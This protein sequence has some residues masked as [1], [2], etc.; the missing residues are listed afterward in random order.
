[1]KA[2]YSLLLLVL[3]FNFAKA[4]NLELPFYDDFEESIGAPGI[5]NNWTIESLEGWQY[6]HIIPGQFVRF[7]NNDLDQ[8]DWLITKKINSTGAENLKVNFSYLYSTNKV[9]P[10]FY[11]TNQYN[12][13]AS[14]STWTELSFSF[15]ANE[16][17]WYSSDDYIIENPG[18]A[19]YFAFQYQVKANAGANFLLDNFSAKSYTPP[20]PF[21]LVGNSEHFEFYTNYADSAEYYFGMKDQL[22]KQFNK[23]ASIWEKPESNIKIYEKKIKVYYSGLSDIDLFDKNTPEWKSGFY[24]SDKFSIYIS[25]VNSPGKSAMYSNIKVLAESELSQLFLTIYTNLHYSYDSECNFIES[26]GLYES[27][28]KP[29]R[30]NVNIALDG[31]GH[32][33]SLADVKGLDKFT[34]KAKRELCVSYV[35]ACILGGAT[36]HIN[37]YYFEELWKYHLYYYYQIDESIALRLSK[38]TDHFNIF[39]I[40]RDDKY[41]NSIVQQ[42]EELLVYYSTSYAL[43]IKHPFNVVI[44]PDEQTGMKL[45]GREGLWYNGGVAMGTDNFNMLSPE[46]LG[47]GLDEALGGLVAHEFFHVI[48]FN[49]LPSRNWPNWQFHLEGSAD[50]NAR[51]SLGL[52]IRRD[53]FWMIEWT[54]SE[55]ATKYNIDLTLAHIS[56]NPNN[57]LDVY[58]LGDLFYEYLYLNHGGYE[59]IKE[60]Y[61]NA[62]DYS[63]FDATFEEIDK[64]YIRYLKRLVNYIP[65]K[66]L[67]E[68]P[69]EDS[70]NDFSNGWSKPSYKNPDNWQI[71]GGGINGSNCARFYTSSDKNTPIESWLISPPLNAKNIDHVNF[72]FDYA[73]YGDGIELELF[74]TNNFKEFIASTNWTSIK[75]I[76]MPTN[77]GWSNSGRITIS[78]P[79]DTI[80]IGIR[81]KSTGVQHLQLYIDNFEVDGTFTGLQNIES[82]NATFL[83]F[84][85]PVTANSVVSFQTKTTGNVNLSLY[86]IQGSKICTL[87]DNNLVAGNHTIPVGNEIRTSG[88]Y[89]CKLITPKGISTKKLIVK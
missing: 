54:F 64:G 45:T 34:N 44:Y 78:N 72:S 18:D 13:I 6:W 26:F 30:I 67:T 5:F 37:P 33:P 76:V 52:D 21:V 17:Q 56:S 66:S 60:F 38:Q 86:E 48:H 1:M 27:G 57:E 82:A 61:N 16:N 4:Q 81:K 2:F 47:N 39:S 7:E 65:P 31:L 84:P 62:L 36:E 24:N 25:P 28:L 89:I 59:K 58:Y 88:V 20:V 35:E 46:F 80:F 68:L 69:F 19:I 41:L 77:W 8:N 71:T 79:P 74:Y 43:N 73:P 75:K 51:H 53:R 50:F 63:V 12:G 9:P 10:H 3:F 40:S 49:I 55:Y 42:L 87:I 83:I 23:L 70:F 32:E 15:S 11:Y 85:N 14:Q 29:S 22:E